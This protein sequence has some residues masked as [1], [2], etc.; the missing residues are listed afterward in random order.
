MGVKDLILQRFSRFIDHFQYLIRR[1]EVFL[2]HIF[3]FSINPFRFNI[4]IV[5]NAFD[6]LLDYGS[7]I[8]L[9][10]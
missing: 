4:I 3:G 10:Y 1:T 2:V 5:V 9:R 7:H 6:F 8:A